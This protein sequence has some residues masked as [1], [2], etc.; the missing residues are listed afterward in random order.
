MRV[1][2]ARMNSIYC[3]FMLAVAVM[4]GKDYYKI[5]GVK[6]TA[7][8][9]EIKVNCHFNCLDSSTDPGFLL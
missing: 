6:R 5:L 7:K 2:V 8:S 1:M 9:A 3:L 4:A